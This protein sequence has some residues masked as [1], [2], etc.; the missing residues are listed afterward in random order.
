VCLQRPV[1]SVVGHLNGVLDDG[2]QQRRRE[3]NALRLLGLLWQGQCL[4]ISASG[5]D[6]HIALDRLGGV[7]GRLKVEH[8]L[9]DEGPARLAC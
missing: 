2:I 1:I 4:S 6:G 7:L 5:L 8:C 3:R 9:A